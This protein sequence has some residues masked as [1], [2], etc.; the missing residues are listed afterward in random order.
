MEG[1]RKMAETKKDAFGFMLKN[2]QVE[3][4]NGMKDHDDPV[5]AFMFGNTKARGDSGKNPSSDENGLLDQ[6]DLG[7]VIQH[8]ET[9][10][11]SA[12]ELK[13]L[14]GK[15]R[16]LLDLFMNKNKS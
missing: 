12:K 7:E 9:L 8:V 4:S 11:T 1:V 16:P 2:H 3:S 14:I 6:V 5:D 10:M 15:M 13:P